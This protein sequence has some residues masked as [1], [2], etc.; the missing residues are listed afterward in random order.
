MTDH[1]H[2]MR[3]MAVIVNGI[4]HGFSVHGETVILRAIGLVP[5]L[6]GTVKTDGINTEQAITDGKK[7]RHHR[8]PV[9]M[10]A[11]ETLPGLLSQAFSSIRDGQIAA[12]AAQGRCCG[13][14]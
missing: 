8:A 4:S 6:E 2:D 1:A 3:L 7:T 14:G 5:A 9:F 10:P 13:D 11:V 12:H